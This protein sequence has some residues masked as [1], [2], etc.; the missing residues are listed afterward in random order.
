MERLIV[1]GLATWRLCSLLQREAG[2]FS[3]FTHVRSLA[4]ARPF[5]SQIL[6]CIYC[7]SVWV[8]APAALLALSDA[9]WL[10]LPLALSAAAILVELCSKRLSK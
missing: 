10:L 6:G 1:A 2:P 5:W 8:G 4:A 3:M 9:W 7:L